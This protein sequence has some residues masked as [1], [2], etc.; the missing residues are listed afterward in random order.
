MT[1]PSIEARVRQVVARTF[2]LTPEQASGALAMGS[3]P[4]WDS[5]G[6]MRLVAAVEDEFN[7]RLPAFAISEVT[8]VDAMVRELS[9][10]TA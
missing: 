7:V 2:S 10:L 1:T 5:L 4:S 6:H 8:S 9:A 3:V